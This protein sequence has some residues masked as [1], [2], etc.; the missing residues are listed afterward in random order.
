MCAHNSAN[1]P[2]FFL[3]HA[4]IDKIW[5]DWQEKSVGHLEVYFRDL[6]RETRLRQAGFHPGDYIDT[7]NL[8]HPDI[9]RFNAERICVNYKDPVHPVYDEI[10]KRLGALSIR[11]IRQIPRRFFRPA[12]S[13]QLKKLGVKRNERRKARRLLK[14]I[15][16]KKKIRGNRDLE[17]IIDKWLG[18][19][20]ARIPFRITSTK[21]RPSRSSDRRHTRW[22]A[23]ATN[24]T[25]MST[26]DTT[27]RFPNISSIH[28]SVGN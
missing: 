11:E 25:R 4:F 9:N 18:F 27:L 19:P 23:K 20:L 10:M 13:R 21:D 2:E 28:F 14:K 22:L 1:A 12:S 24:F 6:P 3:H 17:T 15:E 8:P 26:K 7:L 5:A 16:P